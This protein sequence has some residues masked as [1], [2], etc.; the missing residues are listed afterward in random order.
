[1]KRFAPLVAALGLL[2]SACTLTTPSIPVVISPGV[3]TSPNTSVST[4]YVRATIWQEG[5]Q[6]SP[7]LV[8]LQL[9][10][11]VTVACPVQD[12][13]PT[14]P[15][16][17]DARYG[18]EGSLTIRLGDVESVQ[19][20]QLAENLDLEI[21]GPHFDPSHIPLEQLARIRGAMWTEQWPC[22]LGPRPWQGS[23]I[24]ATDFLWNYT[25]EIREQVVTNLVSLGYTHAV[26]GPIVDSDG[27]HGAWTPND[28]RGKFDQFL[29]MAQYLWDH[30]LVPVVFI[31]P[32]GWSFERTRGELTPLL[33]QPR[34]QRLLRVVVPFGWEPC[35]Y[36]CSSYTW[37]AYARWGRETLPNAL[38][39]LHTVCDVDAPVG[40]DALGDDNGHPNAEGWARVAPWVHVWLS[41][42]CTFE[43]PSGRDD[44]PLT[45]FENWANLFNPSLRGSYADRF[46]HGYAG[47]PTFSAWGPNK[48]IIAC[49]AEYYSFKAFW[50]GGTKEEARTWGDAAVRA[51]AQ[52]YLDGG[53]LPVGSGPVPW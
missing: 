9:D 2:L 44:P 42:S 51:G 20:V 16:T 4:T 45:N 33:L 37:A 1:M 43:N 19:R 49:P 34:A 48:G 35:K 11:G 40:G 29:D 27:Y 36:E 7:D 8:T 28:W 14:C 52:C 32:D 26:I 3:P 46:A 25:P 17:P 39:A 15:L 30:H 24:C 18:H 22:P 5:Q 6:V 50:E 23:N 12:K 38:I 10:N 31:H 21:P 47:W 13:R 41:Q 53:T